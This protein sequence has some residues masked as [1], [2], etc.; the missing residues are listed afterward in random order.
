MYF[1]S[2]AAL[3]NSYIELTGCT[4][5]KRPCSLSDDTPLLHLLSY[6]T[7]NE[8]G[9]DLLYVVISDVVSLLKVLNRISVTCMYLKIVD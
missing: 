7:E 6:S 2:F 4:T 9:N 3:C 5:M 8:S 1:T